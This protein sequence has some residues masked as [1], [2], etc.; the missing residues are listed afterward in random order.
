MVKFSIGPKQKKLLH[1]I[2]AMPE[3]VLLKKVGVKENK[4]KILLPDNIKTCLCNMN[5]KLLIQIINL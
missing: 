4:K 5:F 3:Q 1:A 2:E